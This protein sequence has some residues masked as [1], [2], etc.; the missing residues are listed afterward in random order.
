MEHKLESGNG[1]TNSK[2]NIALIVF[3]LIGAF[4]L[5][6]EH[7]AHLAGWLPYLPYLLLLAC[8][9]MHVFMHGVHGH[10]NHAPSE[11]SNEST[12]EKK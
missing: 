10:G 9:L 12:P 4:F 2:A 6:T 1:T 5:I 8:P 11:T 3:L 7:W